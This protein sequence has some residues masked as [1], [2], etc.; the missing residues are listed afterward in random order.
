MG[1]GVITG[2]IAIARTATAYQ[3]K[4]SDLSWDGVSNAMTRI[5]EVNIGNIAAC[6]PVLKP[7]VRYVRARA[8]GRDPHSIL[9]PRTSDPELHSRWYNRG[10]RTSKQRSGDKNVEYMQQ[11]ASLPP[12]MVKMRTAGI[13][14][15]SIKTET[16]RTESIALPLQ[17]TRKQNVD[18]SIPDVPDMRESHYFQNSRTPQTDSGE[19]QGIKDIV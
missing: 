4:S 2:A 11:E 5:F 1:L 13:E 3:V 14:E 19:F 15:T 9:R 6:V 18:G 8:T 16:S 10:W 17:G 7:F 12:G